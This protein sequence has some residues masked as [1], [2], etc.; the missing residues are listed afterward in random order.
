MRERV[1]VAHV[2]TS[3]RSPAAARWASREAARRGLPLRVARHWTPAVP[4]RAEL[5]VADARD[6]DTVAGA[7]C[8]VVLVPAKPG[9]PVPGETVLGLDVRNPSAGALAF[10]FDTARRR[11]VRLHVVHAWRL[12]PAAADLPFGVPEEDRGAW[13]DHEVQLLA[14]IL[15]PWRAKYPEVDV[16]EDVR[17][18]APAQALVQRYTSTGLLVV[19]RRKGLGPSALVRGLVHGS[20][21]PVAIVPS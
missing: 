21:C 10:A 11:G 18:L 9:Q 19:G 8:P 1:I 20:L 14:D 3:A 5:V 16:L 7:P 17:L 15:R 2:G 6:L 13:E 12:P 4:E